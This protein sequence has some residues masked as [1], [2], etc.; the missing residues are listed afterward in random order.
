LG[1]PWWEPVW[2]SLRPGVLASVSLLY[3]CCCSC[4]R[5]GGRRGSREDR[6]GDKM[7]GG[8]MPQVESMGRL[9]CGW[10]LLS[11][12]GS[13]GWLV[14][15]GG[16]GAPREDWNSARVSG[17]GSP[18]QTICLGWRVPAGTVP[19]PYCVHSAHVRGGRCRLYRQL[20]AVGISRC[21]GACPKYLLR[22]L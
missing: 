18:L 19:V 5:G 7:S 3:S 6:V 14:A 8:R 10:T 9:V 22:Q 15:V 17:E 4:W 13:S 11:I 12:T 2:T 20:T 21:G 16:Y 1:V